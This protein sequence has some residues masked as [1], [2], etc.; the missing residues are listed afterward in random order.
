MTR[1]PISVLIVDDSAVVRQLLSAR[2]GGCADID[3]VR[4][5][6]DPIFAMSAMN[7]SW[8]DVVV[9]DIEMPRMDGLTFLK[10]IMEVRP[11]PVV[12]C[13]TL[14]QQGVKTTMDALAAGAVSIVPKPSIGLK[15]FIEDDSGDIVAAVKAAAAAAAGKVRQPVPAARVAPVPVGARPAVAD[16]GT[17]RVV[18][19]GTST[20]GTNALETVLT[21]LPTNCTGIVVVQHMPEK[22]TAAFAD[23]LNAM[24]AIEV[25]EAVDGDRVLPGRALIAPGGRHLEVNR[26]GAPSPLSATSQQQ[27]RVRVL[28]GPP[29]NR[30][31]PSVD[32]L[33]RS[34]A[35]AAGPNALG[36]IMT[37]MG[38]DGAR[39][40]LE[41]RRAGAAT[42]AQDEATCV[43]YGMPKEAVQLGAVERQAPLG[44]IAEVIRR[45]G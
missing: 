44:S 20:G 11:T 31:R 23:R 30:H 28:D 40:L 15:K 6:A 16:L 2:L 33:F 10:R 35:K 37:G 41:M 9:L 12:I 22:F 38:D 39:G 1:R 3:E 21:G 26:N 25:R 32:V 29:V 14:T 7:R 43:V 27:Y 18:A 17:D 13:S 36:V 34:V 8:P 24:C 45:N 5:A 4:T 19:I 42:V